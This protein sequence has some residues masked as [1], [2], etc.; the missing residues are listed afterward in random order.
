MRKRDHKIEGHGARFPPNGAMPANALAFL[1]AL[2]RIAR[3]RPFS[4]ADGVKLTTDED[5]PRGNVHNPD[6]PRQ[7][8]Q[9]RSC[10][11][12]S[13]GRDHIVP[14]QSMGPEPDGEGTGEM[15]TS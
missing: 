1:E 12:P 9:G 8:M 13:R 15:V 14:V 2:D 4:F 6:L 5:R 3:Q 10:P 7:P 11:V